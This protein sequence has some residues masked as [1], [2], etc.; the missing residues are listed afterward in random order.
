VSSP[1]V[2]LVNI[3]SPA[4][5]NIIIYTNLN[6][7][8]SR[9]NDIN[10]GTYNPNVIETANYSTYFKILYL[11]DSDRGQPSIILED[12]NYIGTVDFIGYAG[13]AQ[14]GQT[15][16][17]IGASMIFSSF[18]KTGQLTIQISNNPVPPKGTLN[19]IAYSNYDSYNI[20]W[21]TIGK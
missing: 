2:Q 3:S 12:T 15:A 21:Q 10:A 8:N 9:V 14:I 6:D 17:G 18:D 1:P 5:G 7:I 11:W 16:T 4:S 13:A 20:L 19:I